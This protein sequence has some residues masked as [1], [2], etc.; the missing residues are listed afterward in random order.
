MIA[1]QQKDGSLVTCNALV[2]AIL[3]G[4]CFRVMLDDGR[5]ATCKPSGRMQLGR[6][7]IAVGDEVV[8][9]FAAGSFEK[10]RITFRFDGSGPVA[11]PRHRRKVR[12]GRARLEFDEQIYG[13]DAA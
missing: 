1:H 2:T 8:C 7:T 13:G 5:L 4:G 12:S 11:K 3:A 9:E 10:G 6:I